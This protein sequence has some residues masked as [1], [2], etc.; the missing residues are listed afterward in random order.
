MSRQALASLNELDWSNIGLPKVP[1]ERASTRICP[2]AGPGGGGRGGGGLHAAAYARRAQTHARGC[3]QHQADTSLVQV[4]S[5]RLNLDRTVPL[6]AGH[7]GSV[8]R[9]LPKNCV[10]VSRKTQG[11]L[12][13]QL[14]SLLLPQHLQLLP[15]V[16]PHLLAQPAMRSECRFGRIATPLIGDRGQDGSS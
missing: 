2:T 6:L 16:W 9:A 1:V 15:S 13:P 11:H 8:G 7:V 10:S 14:V 5:S 4:I 3:T 12:N